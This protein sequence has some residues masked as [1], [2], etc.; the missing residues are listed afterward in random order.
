MQNS[1]KI[2]IID[3]NSQ[4]VLAEF[5]TS[6]IEKAYQMAAE[7]EAMGISC[8]LNAPTLSSELIFAL[9]LDE[10][11]QNEYLLS[12]NEEIEDHEGSCCHNLTDETVI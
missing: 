3:P 10:K 11:A 8:E 4:T 12:V 1:P 7:F 9:G 5:A 6:D 2:Q